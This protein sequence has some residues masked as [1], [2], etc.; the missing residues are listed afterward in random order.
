MRPTLKEMLATTKSEEDCFAWLNEANVHELQEFLR[1]VNA[2]R[3]QAFALARLEIRLAE[4][5]RRSHWVLWATL[6][7]AATAAIASVAALFR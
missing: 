7:A 2:E 3:F 4:E 5:M 1:N 6:I